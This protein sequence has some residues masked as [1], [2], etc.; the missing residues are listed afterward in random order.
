MASAKAP[1]GPK[2]RI[3]RIKINRQGFDWRGKYY[4]DET[5]G[6]IYTDTFRAADREAAK[7]HVRKRHPN[8]RF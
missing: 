4:D 1:K 3:E 5:T 6:D 8:A 2:I 7:A